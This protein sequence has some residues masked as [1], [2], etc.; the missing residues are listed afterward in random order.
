ML[1]V[2]GLERLP[3]SSIL[4]LH[5][6]H[7]AVHYSQLLSTVFSGYPLGSIAFKATRWLARSLQYPKFLAKDCVIL[8]IEILVDAIGNIS[9]DA[10]CMVADS[11]Q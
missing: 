5:L 7:I 4:A 10:R 3:T 6:Y 2:R 9:V 11:C 1:A 8:R